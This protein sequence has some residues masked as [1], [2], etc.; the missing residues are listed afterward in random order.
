MQKV[1][2]QGHRVNLFQ[3]VRVTIELIKWHR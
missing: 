1:K 2:V 3:P